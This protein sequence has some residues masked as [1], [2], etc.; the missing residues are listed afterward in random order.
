MSGYLKNEREADQK[1]FSQS[2]EKLIG[3]TAQDI[4]RSYP[5]FSDAD[6]KLEKCLEYAN[7]YS[8][9]VLNRAQIEDPEIFAVKGMNKEELCAYMARNMCLNEAQM[10]ARL[11]RETTARINEKNYLSDEI[12]RQYNG[13]HK[14][15]PY[16]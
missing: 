1:I 3:R 9:T 14:F 2:N 10:R 8:M 5:D 6:L 13:G 15:H 16:L 7:A 11:F 4:Y 12:R